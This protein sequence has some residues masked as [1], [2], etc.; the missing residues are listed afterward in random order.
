MR[1]IAYDDYPAFVPSWQ[2]GPIIQTK[3]DMPSQ[4]TKLSS[5]DRTYPNDLGAVSHHLTY[6]EIPVDEITI[7][8]LVGG[9]LIECSPIFFRFGFQYCGAVRR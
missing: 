6:S 1:R 2:L 3:L 9:G 7:L 5:D 4:R 8:E